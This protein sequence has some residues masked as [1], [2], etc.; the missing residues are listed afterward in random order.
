MCLP[1]LAW[2]CFMHLVLCCAGE[3]TPSLMQVSRMLP[4]ERCVQSYASGSYFTVCAQSH[5]I[6]I[7]FLTCLLGSAV[8]KHL[9]IENPVI[10]FSASVAFLRG[11][12]C[13]LMFKGALQM[14]SVEGLSVSLSLQNPEACSVVLSDPQD[15]MCGCWRE[16]VRLGNSCLIYL[17]CPSLFMH[18]EEPL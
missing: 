11:L 12:D 3:G 17:L 10:G 5:F 6:F 4:T 2:F 7:K 9:L 14:L 18:V 8:S 15:C 13:V 1:A 16:E